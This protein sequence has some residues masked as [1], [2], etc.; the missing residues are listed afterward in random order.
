MGDRSGLYAIV[1]DAATQRVLV[2]ATPSGMSL[3]FVGL[4]PGDWSVV[5]G[6]EAKGIMRAERAVEHATGL[7]VTTLYATE[8]PKGREDVHRVL[9]IHAYASSGAQAQPTAPY[10]WVA[11]AESAA[12]DWARPFMANA[13]AANDAVSR[14]GSPVAPWWRPGW[15][16]EALEWL[17][18]QLA[19]A[20]RGRVG[21]VDQVKNDWQSIV[22]RAPSDQGDVYLKALA[23]PATQE[24]TILRDILPRD[25]AVPRLLASDVDRGL[26]LMEDVGGVN[27]AD[28]SRGDLA[29][30]DLL[31]LAEGY[32]RLQRSTGAV[33]PES[34]IDCRLEL[35]PELHSRAVD[36]QPTLL[37][38]C[39]DPPSPE[40]IMTLREVVLAVAQACA[41]A[42]ELGI[43][44][45]LTHGD[46]DGNSIV[47]PHGPAFFDWGAACLTHPFLDVFEFRDSVRTV[48]GESAAEAAVDK[49]LE[50][51][52]S[53]GSTPD[54][55]RTVALLGAVRSVPWLLLAARAI[56]H[57]PPATAPL[58]T[59]PYSPVAAS[60]RQWQAWLLNQLRSLRRDMSRQ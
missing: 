14:E 2:A 8:W 48:G 32:A 25:A 21:R 22:M 26:L 29:P 9:R 1:R 35:M 4:A 16:D 20:G 38:G 13:V 49:Y 28:C 10:T 11:R 59:A 7:R 42:A 31:A 60:A 23:P 37:T 36:D 30:G 34:V 40:D 5:D 57:L 24:L 43:P 55:R 12:L 47:T 56:R 54:L 3:P 45:H 27:P 44:A 46:L 51:W 39:D 15:A 19:A 33:A 41:S 6:R 17:D 50:E 53:Y 52:T 58:R 18:S